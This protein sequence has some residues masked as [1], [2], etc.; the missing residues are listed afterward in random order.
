MTFFRHKNLFI[1]L[2]L[3]L[4]FPFVATASEIRLDAS[5]V[6]IETGEQFIIT[7]MMYADEPVNAIEGQLVFVPDTLEVKEIRDGNSSVNLWIEKPRLESTDIIVF[8]GITPGGFNG[9]N[10]R[11]FSV[12]FEAKQDGTAFIALEKV[13]ALRNDGL[14]T[15]ESLTIL[16]VRV[17][18]KRG[19]SNTRRE[20]LED[21]I[22]PEPFTP[23]ITHD[24]S[25]FEDKWFIVFATQDKD[26]GISRYEAKEYRFKPFSFISLWKV[27]ES[28]YVLR[29]QAFKSHIVVQAIDNTGNTRV[30]Y[31]APMHPLAW[32]EYAFYWII[33]IGMLCG[34]LLI[35]SKIWKRK[36]F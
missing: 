25:L 34:V 23:T 1:S 28:P 11:L 33:I 5:K 35:V 36:I 26:S 14:G 20:I 21:T 10:N 31:V 24:P 2:I 8:S 27:A 32:Y 19:D 18:V 17:V 15:E 7:V 22:P 3:L 6:E 16:D 30:A 4:I 9:V 13:K 12:V 29:D